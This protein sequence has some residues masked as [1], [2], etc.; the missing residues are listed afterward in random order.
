MST[1]I[2]FPCTLVLAVLGVRAV[3]AQGYQAMPGVLTPPPE[4]QPDSIRT[5]APVAQEAVPPLQGPGPGLSRWITYQRP[6]CCGNVG[7]DGPIFA[8]LYTLTGVEIPA[9]GKFFGHVLE[10]GWVVQGGGRSLFF[11][12]AMDRDWNIDLSISNVYNLGQ[13]NDIKVPLNQLVPNQNIPANPPVVHQLINATVRELN[14]TYV[15]AAFGREWYFHRP[16]SAWIHTWRAGVAA[17]GRLGSERLELVE[18]GHHSDIIGGM[19]ISLNADVEMPCGCCTFL[20]G[21]RAEWGY[22]FSDILDAQ[23]SQDA[24]DIQDVNILFTVGVRF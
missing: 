22:N 17:G 18:V 12:S 5:P 10:T 9:Q 11:N 3:G 4:M 20:A 8:E 1:K 16:A 13:H 21:M 24:S 7:C 15:S 23:K 2:I 6:D 14:R 19:F